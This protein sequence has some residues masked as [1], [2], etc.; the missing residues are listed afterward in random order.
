MAYARHETF[1]EGV[2]RHPILPCN[3]R[4][5]L[6][7]RRG[8]GIHCHDHCVRT[9]YYGAPVTTPPREPYRNRMRKMIRTALAEL[10]LPDD[11]NV[12]LA[13]VLSRLELWNKRLTKGWQAEAAGRLAQ[14]DPLD[15]IAT[16]VAW[17]M[18]EAEYRDK[19]SRAA[20]GPDFYQSPRRLRRYESRSLSIW[21]RGAWNSRGWPSQAY[22]R[23]CMSHVVGMLIAYRAPTKLLSVAAQLTRIVGPRVREEMVQLQRDRAARERSKEERNRKKWAPYGYSA[24]G[25]FDIFRSDDYQQQL[26][27]D[28]DGDQ[29]NT[30]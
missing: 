14:L 21:L 13:A 10:P 27:N 11:V 6:I 1:A 7:R 15:L 22:P 19:Y 9:R 28:N 17:F 24:D 18:Y 29:E 5:C 8:V 20:D 30:D 2:A 12:Y 3:V 16:V 26:A 23:D 4:T 25:S